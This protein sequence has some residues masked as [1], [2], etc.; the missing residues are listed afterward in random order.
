MSKR[1]SPTADD[2][3]GARF[4]ARMTQARAASLIGAATRTW[5]DWEGGRRRMPW[6]KYRLFLTLTERK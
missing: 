1:P 3:Y 6:A 2:V 5:Q 4:N